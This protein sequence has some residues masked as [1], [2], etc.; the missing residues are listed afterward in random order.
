[1]VEEIYMLGYVGQYIDGDDN[2][3]KYISGVQTL[4]S[5][6]AKINYDWFIEPVCSQS[7]IDWSCNDV[8]LYRQ[9]LTMSNDF[10]YLLKDDYGVWI[11]MRLSK[12]HK[13]NSLFLGVVTSPKEARINY[14]Q[15]HPEP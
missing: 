14:E 5:I 15:Q 13:R 7:S 2:T 4:V 11:T 3:L 10:L 1:M 8:K 9:N 12:V 6:D